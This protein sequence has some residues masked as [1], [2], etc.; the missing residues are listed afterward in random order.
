MIKMIKL[1]LKRG[2]TS[3]GMLISLIMGIACMLYQLIPWI[4][5][6]EESK[7]YIDLALQLNPDD[8]R[9]LK[10]RDIIYEKINSSKEIIKLIQSLKVKER[11][12]NAKK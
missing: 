2:C 11:N 8:E 1:E 6:F 5:K 4:N 7:Q 12:K 9:L 3:I 10:N